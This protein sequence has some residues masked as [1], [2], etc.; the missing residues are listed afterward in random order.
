MRR[1]IL[2]LPMAM[3][4]LFCV[5]PASARDYLVSESQPTV[6]GCYRQEYVPATIHVNTRGKKLHPERVVWRHDGDVIRRVRLP[7][8]YLQTRRVVERDH[9]TRV[10]VDCDPPP[11]PA[12]APPRPLSIVPIWHVWWHH[13]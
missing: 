2:A 4:A 10:R 7:A 3:A 12:A 5:A 9:F 6:L 13:R 1:S 8:V 11:A